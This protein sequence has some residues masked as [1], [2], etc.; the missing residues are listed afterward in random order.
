MMS[1]LAAASEELGLLPTRDPVSQGLVAVMIVGVFVLLALEK[2][3]RVLVIASTVG[4]MWLVTYLTPYH[5]IKTDISFI[6]FFQ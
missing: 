4:L 3:H 6:Y 5:L 2:A 1:P